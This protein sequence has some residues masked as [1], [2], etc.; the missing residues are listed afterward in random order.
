M[1]R[2]DS[3]LLSAEEIIDVLVDVAKLDTGAV[4]AAI[5]DVDL[6]KILSEL[7][8]QFSSIAELRNLKLRVGPCRVIVRSDRRLLRRVLQN[9][10]ANALRYT[11]SG[12][13]LIGVRRLAGGRIRIDV[14]DTGAG[15]PAEAISEIFEEFRR[16]G[17]SSPW[18]EKGLGLG[19]AICTRI[20]KLIGHRLSVKSVLGR[21]STFSVNLDNF[22]VNTDVPLA[23]ALPAMQAQFS[24]AQLKVL[25]VDDDAEVADAMLMLLR[26][27]GVSCKQANDRKG[28]LAAA[29]LFQP[30]V[31]I[32]DYQFDDAHSGNGLQI[33]QAL[34]DLKPEC[35]PAAIMIT[36]NRSVELLESAKKLGVPLLHKPLRAARLRSLLESIS[37]GYTKQI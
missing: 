21:G 28:A 17:Q 36:A 27:W 31:I 35:P 14:T 19:L 10:I 12:G 32:V 15:I 11:A 5:E 16:G 30:D 24:V 8:N 26:T 1:Q 20:C 33:I 7:A 18:G 9:L 29:Q 3:A 13:I 34:R 37:R 4:S 25:C 22:R 23:A 2:I 6:Q